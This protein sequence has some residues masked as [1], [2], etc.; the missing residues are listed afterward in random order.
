LPWTKAS[1]VVE[2]QRRRRKLAGQGG[3]HGRVRVG[4]R[5]QGAT[6]GE[7][8]ARTKAGSILTAENTSRLYGTRERLL[9]RQE[10][11]VARV[12]TIIRRLVRLGV[13]TVVR[14]I[15]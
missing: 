11:D 1:R 4:S 2:V 13:P 7:N 3:N 14:D 10:D 8:R 6:A 5:G 9:G 12:P 15:A